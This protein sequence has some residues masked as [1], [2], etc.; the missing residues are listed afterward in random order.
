MPDSAS[1]MCAVGDLGSNTFHLM[2]AEVSGPRINIIDRIRVPVRLAAGLDEDDYLTQESQERAF[3]CLEQF[4]QR[5]Q[6][7]PPEYVNFAGT[8]ALRKAKNAEPFVEKASKILGYRINIISGYEEARLVFAGVARNIEP[9]NKKRLMIDIGGGSTEFAIGR[10]FEPFIMESIDA[11]CLSVAIRFFKD[12]LITKED[13]HNAII[14]AGL[15]LSPIIARLKAVG[16]SSAIGSSGSIQAI[17][18]VVQYYSWCDDGISYS[19]I[20]N[21]RKYLIEK[22]RFEKELFPE[23]SE[24]RAKV[25]AGGVAVLYSIFKNLGVDHI[26]VSDGGIREGLLLDLSGRI[27]HHDVRDTSISVFAKKYNVDMDQSDRVFSNAEKIYNKVLNNW[28][29]AEPNCKELLRWAS[30]VHE[31]GLSV[32]HGR[33][34]KHSAYLVRY[35]NLAGFSRENQMLLGFIVRAHRKKFPQN[36][37][38]KLSEKNRYLATSLSV[39]IRISVILCRSRNNLP[40]DLME[41]ES[42]KFSIGLK[43]PDGWLESNP[44]TNA[45]LEQE[46]IYLSEIGWELNF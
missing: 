6:N 44:L 24:D 3:E 38:N 11:G 5:L 22:G 28:E 33:Y 15:K 7:F 35:S 30:D 36:A 40:I 39:I 42:G 23:I 31:V 17:E 26:S 14:A 37:L 25:F 16:W 41:I 9:D 29:L 45:G 21:L 8:N 43:F 12:E 19:S 18:K 4:R 10:R 32:S 2:I 46:K 20:S 13:M 34:H 1:V 27:D